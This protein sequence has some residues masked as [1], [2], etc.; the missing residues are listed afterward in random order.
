[1]K[2]NALS[3]ELLLKIEKPARYVG[4]E[5]NAYNKDFDSFPV[6]VCFCFPDV[7]EIGTANLGMQIIYEQFNRRSDAMCDRVYTPWLDLAK[8]MHDE[9]IPLFGVES[10]RNV[11]DFDFLLI[12]LSYEMCYTNV[13]E[14]LSLSQIPLLSTERKE[15][16]PIVIGGGACAYN[17]EP[18]ADFF[19]VFYIGEAET[20][21]DHMV[22][23]Y[24]EC[25]KNGL[26]RDEILEKLA[27][28]EGLYVPKFYDVAYSEDGT[29]ASFTPNN[30][31]AKANI[32]RQTADM[33][34][35]SLP[36]PRRPIVPY[37]R[38]MMD[39]ATLEVMRG[40]IRGCRFCQAGMIYRPTR[41]RDI[42]ELKKIAKEMLESSGYDEINLS[43]LSSS[44]HSE[45]KE[46]LDFLAPYCEARHINIGIPSL[47]IDAF[48][49]DV[50][51]KIQDVNKSSLTFAPEAGS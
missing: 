18:I 44:D 2:K 36:Y 39:R 49:L 8:I 43:S 25:R 28:I 5:Y 34:D 33:R 48:S 21:Y 22:E 12:T 46:L 31:H 50:M 38:G 3:D 15:S 19:D 32:K 51:G 20:Q 29:I 1:M 13:L 35:G 41:N 14:T 30:S 24:K 10:Q 9:K 23:V 27:E 37:D 16:D 7:Y 6:R 11:K 40:C 17:P 4:G 26:S 45:L 47:R 42:S